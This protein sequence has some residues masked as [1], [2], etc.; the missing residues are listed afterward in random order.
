MDSQRGAS[1]QAA[2]ALVSSSDEGVIALA[3]SLGKL[4]VVLVTS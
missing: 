3:D 1:P 4:G 2:V